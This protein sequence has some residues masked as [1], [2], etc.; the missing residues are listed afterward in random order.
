M[1]ED[2]SKPGF[3]AQC[4]MFPPFR[5]LIT[6]VWIFA[7]AQFLLQAEAR[8]FAVEREGKMADMEALQQEL[9]AKEV[10]VAQRES[11][12]WSAEAAL[13]EQRRET[14]T[15]ISKADPSQLSSSWLDA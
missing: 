1:V 6:D 8:S 4:C 11:Q 14:S 3:A 2:S 7:P 15:A 10:D 5:Y 13:A 9:R 12:L